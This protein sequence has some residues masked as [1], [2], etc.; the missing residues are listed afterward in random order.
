MSIRGGMAAAAAPAAARGDGGGERGRGGRIAEFIGSVPAVTLAV[1]ALLVGVFVLTELGDFYAALSVAAIVPARVMRGEVWRL[2]TC[3]GVHGSLLHIFFNGASVLALGGACAAP[4]VLLRAVR[5]APGAQPARHRPPP[6]LARAAQAR[7]SRCWARLRLR[8]C[9]RC[10]R[11]CAA[12]CTWRW[13]TPRA[14]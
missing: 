7:W 11:R 5:R 9:W 14:A 10:T 12:C 3:A 2:V 6:P 1:L 4:K 8:R 13:R